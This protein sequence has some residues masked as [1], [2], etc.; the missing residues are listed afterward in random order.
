MTPAERKPSWLKA[1]LSGG[2]GYRALAQKIQ[3]AGLNTVCEE[4]HCPNKGECWSRGVATLMILGDTC[5]RA[6][7]FCNV[8][9]GKP[10][11]T[12]IEEPLRV[13][14]TVKAMGLRYLT[15][16]SVDRDDLVDQGAE[17]WSETI[18]RIKLLVPEIRIET[19]VP[20]FQGNCTLLDL[21]L[22]AGPDVLNHNLETVPRLQRMIRKFANWDHSLQILDHA[23]ARGFKTKTG[24]M[25]GLGETDAE[26]LAFLQ[27]AA[28][29]QVDIVTIGQYL[30]PSMRNIAVQRY[31]E[32]RVFR[33]YAS[34]ALEIGI[35][36]CASGPLVRS[37]WH[38]EELL[39]I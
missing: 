7:A 23:K 26:V 34:Y 15:L 4:A 9:S 6:C 3:G 2:A 10:A 12:D 36:R 5:T 17:I 24:I 33:D 13:A 16:T 18:R 1:P 31:V 37:S 20:D 27:V 39:G 19:L 14:Q 30:Q 32:P 25:V 38:A 29:H 35:A 21:V 11:Q 8:N 28:E 22:D